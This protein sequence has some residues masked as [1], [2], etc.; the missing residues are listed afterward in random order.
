[1][2]T[3]APARLAARKRVRRESR[4]KTTA[5]SGGAVNQTFPQDPQGLCLLM[6]KPEFRKIVAF[7]FTSD[8]RGSALLS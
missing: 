6:G 7:A 8:Q 5:E 3:P 4:V 1:M 2:A